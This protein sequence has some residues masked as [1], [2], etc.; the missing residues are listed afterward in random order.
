MRTTKLYQ[1]GMLFMLSSFSLGTTLPVMN[2]L[3]LDKGL[4]LSTLA[5]AMGAYS[6]VVVITEIPSGLASDYFGRKACFLFSKFASAVGSLLL[7]FGNSLVALALAVLFLGLARAFISG[8]FEALAI[9]WHNDTYG[10]QGLH[11]ITMLISVWD[12]IGLSAGA[13][14][15][16]FITTWVRRGFPLSSGYD[17]NFLVSAVLNL[18]VL[19]LALVLIHEKRIVSS[20]GDREI[21]LRPV[22]RLIVGN[23][24][25]A[26]LLL[27]AGATGFLLSSIE[28]YWQPRLVEIGNG[29]ES[30]AIFL[31]V[32]AF[33]GFMSALVGAYAS[34]KVMD[35]F[36]KSVLGVYVVLRLVMV[37]SILALSSVWHQGPY[38]AAFGAFYLF[39]G[40]VEVSGQ[41]MTN[42]L[43]PSHIRSSVLSV[44]SF[45]MQVG[46]LVASAFAAVWLHATTQ[47]IASVWKASAVVVLVVLLPLVVFY[48][49]WKDQVVPK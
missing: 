48:R 12:T 24:L 35:R 15:S 2:L 29:S 3:L 5:L 14:A 7:V 33:I 23:K 26:L 27:A 49:R 39:L 21:G 30:T 44:S 36:P 43:T 9:D 32:L 31:G 40:M 47:G 38:T 20:E 16:G 28:K 4:N 37:V 25:L 6:L 46:G 10:V 17:G 1:L 45:S 19:L 22:F 11:R 34:T 8:S 42:S 18:A 13:L 41:V